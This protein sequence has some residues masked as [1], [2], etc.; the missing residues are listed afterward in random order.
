MIIFPGKSY[1]RSLLATNFLM[2][3]PCSPSYL[4]NMPFTSDPASSD[5]LD[6]AFFFFVLQGPYYYVKQAFT[7]VLMGG[8]STEWKQLK[9]ENRMWWQW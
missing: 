9:S 5:E 6:S 8:Y 1:F 4:Q 3:G 2:L 7:E